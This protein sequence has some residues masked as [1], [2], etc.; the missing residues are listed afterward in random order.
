MRDNTAA[1]DLAVVLLWYCWAPE[2]TGRLLNVGGKPG[3]CSLSA[4][5]SSGWLGT[6]KPPTNLQINL[7]QLLSVFKRISSSGNAQTT[8]RVRIYTK[9]SSIIKK[10][11][12][13]EL[14]SE[15]LLNDWTVEYRDNETNEVGFHEIETL[16]PVCFEIFS[17]WSLVRAGSEE[18]HCTAYNFTQV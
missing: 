10:F 15:C 2:L 14:W 12:N 9:S 3:L 5:L 16:L 13:V 6:V 18:L 7:H 8:V 17:I 11:A 4:F 1:P